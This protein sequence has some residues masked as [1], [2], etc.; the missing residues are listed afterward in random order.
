MFTE[1][2]ESYKQMPLLSNCTAKENTPLLRVL[3]CFILSCLMLRKTDLF[4]L[5]CKHQN[6]V[7]SVMQQLYSYKVTS[8]VLLKN[9]T[10]IKKICIFFKYEYTLKVGEIAAASL[11]VSYMAQVL[12]LKL[13]FSTM[14]N[15]KV[16]HPPLWG[17]QINTV[18]KP[19]VQHKSKGD[20]WW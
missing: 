20:I 17:L 11:L 19:F 14:S 7:T 12:S 16:P 18:Q 5:Q 3:F 9:R 15:A 6:A 10:F 1:T 2:A 4:I 13:S 8:L